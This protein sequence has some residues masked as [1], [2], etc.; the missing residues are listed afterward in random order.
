MVY[1]FYFKNYLYK[2]Y[3]VYDQGLFDLVFKNSFK[4][5]KF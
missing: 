1:L 4:F 3:K 5:L 2:L